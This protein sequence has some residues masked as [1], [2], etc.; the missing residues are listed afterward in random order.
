MKARTMYK[1]I[2]SVFKISL[3]TLK[4]ARPLTKNAVNGVTKR[5]YEYRI[6]EIIIIYC[7]AFKL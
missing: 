5:H 1:C 7:L 4:Y 3:N 6:V 2:K